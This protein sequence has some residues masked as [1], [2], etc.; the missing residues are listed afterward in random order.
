MALPVVAVRIG[1]AG[2]VSQ[3]EQV[4]SIDEL[5]GMREIIAPGN[6]NGAAVGV[7]DHDFIVCA[8]MFAVHEYRYAGGGKLPDEAGWNAFGLLGVGDYPDFNAALV[9][10]DQR[11]GDADV[12]KAVSL[13]E[14][15]LLGLPDGLHD[16]SGGIVA[17]SE[18]DLDGAG[19]RLWGR[20]RLQR[21]GLT[22]PYQAGCKQELRQHRLQ[23][24]VQYRFW[25]QPFSRLWPVRLL[26]FP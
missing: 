24:S 3:N 6:N 12:G 10:L 7:D 1:N 17:G 15:L 20:R 26:H 16:Q 13:Y 21:S 19:C 11:I 8:G 23:P 22:S 5:G 25:Q 14:Y 2:I 4:F 9:C 18:G